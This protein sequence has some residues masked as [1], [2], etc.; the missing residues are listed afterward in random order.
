MSQKPP[1]EQAIKPF[2]ACPTCKKV[3]QTRND[4]LDDPDIAIVGYEVHFEELTEGLFLFK[5]SCG[6]TIT[7]KAGSFRD[8]YDGPIFEARMTG[9]D[10]CPE[11]C[12]VKHEL[13]PCSAKCECAYVRE[14]IQLLMAWLKMDVT[15]GRLPSRNLN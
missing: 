1:R 14:I 6:A 4:F 7:L 13:R 5:H 3:W 8:L 15:A 2:K 11:Y 12:L 10:D 9:T